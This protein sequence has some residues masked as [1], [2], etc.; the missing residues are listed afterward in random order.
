M[1]IL[2]LQDLKLFTGTFQVKLDLFYWLKVSVPFIIIV[3]WLFDK[4]IEGIKTV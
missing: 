4:K 3:L 2:Y 1:M